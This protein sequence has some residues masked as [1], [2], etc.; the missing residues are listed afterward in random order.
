MYHSK[1]GVQRISRL[2]SATEKGTM[3]NFDFV[4]IDEK[5]ITE[6]IVYLEI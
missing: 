2:I 3:K 5:K 4:S 1:S 6:D